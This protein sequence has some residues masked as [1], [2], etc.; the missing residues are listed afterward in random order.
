[1]VVGHLAAQ[2]KV[3]QSLVGLFPDSVVVD[4]RQR[5]S[6]GY[7]AVHIVVS[8]LER[9][10]EV[11][12]RTELQ[13]LWAQASERLSDEVDPMIK[14]GGGPDLIARRLAE[15]SQLLYALEFDRIEASLK[16]GLEQAMRVRFERLVRL[17][18][19]LGR[20]D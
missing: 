4:R 3:V 15:E 13:H 5:P 19:N 20:E 6:Y 2:D 14:Y 8:A 17:V 12:V 11:Q 10:V 16:P 7:R 1:V 18:S 9:L